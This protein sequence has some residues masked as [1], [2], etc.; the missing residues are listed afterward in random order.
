VLLLP[1]QK[2]AQISQILSTTR[3][4]L[5][6][7]KHGMSVGLILDQET[8]SSRG[9]WIVF[10]GT[11]RSDFKDSKEVKTTVAWLDD[12]PLSVGRVYQALHGHQWV[13]AKIQSID[14]VLDIHSLGRADGAELKSNEIG[15]VTLQM[16]QSFP[17]LAY[18]E[19]RTLGAMILVDPASNK[20]SGAVLIR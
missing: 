12:E 5:S 14:Y 16:A 19:S 4:P 18:S 8:D 1:S 15:G 7:A 13:K 11:G 3:E 9:D 17:H 2:K 20:T 6:A 10:D